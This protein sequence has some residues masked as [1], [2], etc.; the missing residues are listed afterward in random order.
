MV[1]LCCISPFQ[2]VCSLWC[3][4]YETY[5][6][7]FHW[8]IHE[9]S[10]SSQDKSIKGGNLG[11]PKTHLFHQEQILSHVFFFSCDLWKL[12]SIFGPFGPWIPVVWDEVGGLRL[13]TKTTK[14]WSA[15][16]FSGLPQIVF[17]HAWMSQEISEWL[18]SGLQPQY[19]PFISRLYPI[20]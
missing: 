19:T 1:A 13:P 15:S 2:G 17:R 9:N 16:M 20:Y 10:S 4:A 12:W 8:K 11:L 5:D 7:I 18:L 6:S 14:K 3:Q